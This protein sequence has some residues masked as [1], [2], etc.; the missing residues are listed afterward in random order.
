V[1]EKATSAPGTSRAVLVARTLAARAG[2]LPIQKILRE[3]RSRDMEPGGLRA[4][5]VFG[6]TGERVTR[7][8]AD[9]VASVDVWEIDRSLEPALRRN[10]P[11]AT[12]KI[13]DSFQ[14]I[15]RTRQ[16]WDLVFIDNPMWPQEHFGILPKVFRVLSPRAALVTNVLPEVNPVTARRYP[17]ILGA[18]HLHRRRAF[19]GTAT[20]ERVPVPAML[21]VY[22]QLAREHG[23]AM[24]WHHLVQCRELEGFVPRKVSIFKLTLGLERT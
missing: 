4:L 6:Y 21:E 14:E 8:Y 12:V 9:A 11:A 3:L 10:V 17:H 22:G 23:F 7:F 18:E 15:E 20:P 13:T 24:S 1:T 5:E 16:R 19:Y 2:L